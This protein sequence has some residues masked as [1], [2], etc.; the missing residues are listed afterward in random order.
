MKHAA[1]MQYDGS[2]GSVVTH[3]TEKD[4]IAGTVWRFIM[5]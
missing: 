3:R 5:D 2:F 1:V 4:T